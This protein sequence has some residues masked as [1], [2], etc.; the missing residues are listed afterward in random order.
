ME[1]TLGQKPS[2]LKVDINYSEDRDKEEEKDKVDKNDLSSTSNIFKKSV[3]STFDPSPFA[4]STSTL[5]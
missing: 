5:G 4:K 2:N 1:L 3:I